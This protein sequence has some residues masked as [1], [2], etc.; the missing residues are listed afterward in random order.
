MQ[1]KTRDLHLGGGGIHGGQQASGGGGGRGIRRPG[2]GAQAGQTPGS[3]HG[4]RSQKS[5][6]LSAFALSGSYG[7]NFSRRN[8]RPDSLDSTRAQQRRSAARRGC[9]LRSRTPAGKT[10]RSRNSL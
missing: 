4:H 10:I 9:G 8:R 6:H 7:G 3:S 5:P 1:T 2:S